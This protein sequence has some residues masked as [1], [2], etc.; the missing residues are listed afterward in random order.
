MS[1]ERM[2]VAHPVRCLQLLIK[3]LPLEKHL[4]GTAIDRKRTVV[5]KHKQMTEFGRTVVPEIHALIIQ[6]LG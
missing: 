3:Q 2:P 6:V 1:D 4:L 5:V